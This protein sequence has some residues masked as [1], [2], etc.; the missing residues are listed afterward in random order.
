[1]RGLSVAL[2]LL[3]LVGLGAIAGRG[4]F[5]QVAT[6]APSTATG[7]ADATPAAGTEA[8]ERNAFLDAFAAALGVTDQT[9]IDAAIQTAID[10]VLADRVAAGELTQEQADA[11]EARVAAGDPHG[12]GLLGGGRGDHGHDAIDKGTNGRDD[13]DTDDND[14]DDANGTAPAEATP[15]AGVATE[16]A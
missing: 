2:A 13:N 1:M 12:F 8:S 5:A 7:G 6:P 15:S 4:V 10:Q 14:S 9:R 16:L 3:A 11:I